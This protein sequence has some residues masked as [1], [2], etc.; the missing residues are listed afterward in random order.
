M[1]GY[2]L[3]S[4]HL[5]TRCGQVGLSIMSAET[6]YLMAC[7]FIGSLCWLEGLYLGRFGKSISP[8]AKVNRP[9][10]IWKKGAGREEVRTSCARKCRAA[11]G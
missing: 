8:T 2:D 7:I 10:E 6:H 1:W 5:R 3:P 9:V 4:V 11:Y